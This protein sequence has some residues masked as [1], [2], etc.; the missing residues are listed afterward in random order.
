MMW[1][2]LGTLRPQFAFVGHHKCATQFVEAV[3]SDICRQKDLTARTFDARHPRVS[4]RWLRTTDFLILTDFI[5]TM[6]DLDRLGARGFHIIRDPRDLLVSMY[7]SHRYSHP[8]SHPEIEKNR[9]VL[10]GLGELDGLWYMMEESEFFQR[11]VG[12]FARWDYQQGRFLETTFER[13]TADPYREFSRILT[14]LGLPVRS[15][16]LAGTLER[17]SFEELQRRWARRNPEAQVN[18]YRRGIAGDWR[19]H[20]QGR[21][22]ERFRESYGDLLIRLGYERDLVW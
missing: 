15:D 5:E 10:A 7:F 11:V 4:G 12:A 16:Q 19:D 14:F 21:V 8:R 13:L 17:N 6:V 3:L 1:P 2:F 9:S 22:R 18:H 20:L